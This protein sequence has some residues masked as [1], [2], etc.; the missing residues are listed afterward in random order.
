MLPTIPAVMEA[1]NIAIFPASLR[2]DIIWAGASPK[3]RVSTNNDIVNPIP[4]RQATPN[5]IFQFE[6]AGVSPNPVLTAN[7]LANVIP[8][9]LPSTNPKK[10][11]IPTPPISGEYWNTLKYEGLV[12]C[13]PALAKAKIG[14]IK[15]LTHGVRVRSN[16]AANPSVPFLAGSIGTMNAI[17]TPDIVA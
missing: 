7:Q 16:I 12:I 3:E 11:P 13:T 15:K 10:M 1:N 14:I 4:P 6:L 5:S 9:G 8:S 17:T 2:L